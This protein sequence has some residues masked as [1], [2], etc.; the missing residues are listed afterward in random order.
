MLVFE[1][2]NKQRGTSHHPMSDA[3]EAA[4][5]LEDLPVANPAKAVA[6]AAAWLESIEL[7]TGFTVAHRLRI[8][9][10]IDEAA[11][12]SLKQLTL[13]YVGARAGVAAG[14]AD[15]WRAL[16]EYLEKLASAYAQGIEACE[17]RPEPE[18][19][20]RMPLFLTRTMRA[21]ASKIAVGWMRYLPPDRSS[22]ETLVRCYRIAAGHKLVTAPVQAYP[23][24][25]AMTCVASELSAAVMFAAAAPETL[26]PRQIELAYRVAC[27]YAGAF[28]C[29]ATRDEHC[30]MYM[31]LERPGP[32][33]RILNDLEATGAKVFFA[34]GSVLAKLNAVLDET[35]SSVRGPFGDE[36]GRTE[37]LAALQHAAVFWS[38]NAPVRRE[39]RTRIDS[40]IR[41]VVGVR[42][43]QLELGLAEDSREESVDWGLDASGDAAVERTSPPPIQTT[44]TPDTWT[45]TDFSSRGI[46][47]RFFRRPAAQLG[48]G[49]LFGFRL[50]RSSRWC[51]AIVR[52]LRRDGHNH[53]DI[54]AEIIAKGADLVG[55]E[56][57]VGDA[58]RTPAH[59][60]V[61]H[62]R[63][64]L[65]PDAPVLKN[66]PSLLFEPGTNMSGQM[67]FM[68]LDN[69][70]RRIRLGSV[71]ESVDGWD[72]VSF[73]WLDG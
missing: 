5:L 71:M 21:V 47:A 11:N 27:A 66:E 24:E 19:T 42:N 7:E 48:I 58:P 35:G 33:V 15:S 23:A 40:V 1:W 55:L 41:V 18:L 44:A 59:S 32:P 10:M 72:R 70:A 57:A 63:A 60:R 61:M 50:E 37:T 28:A 29:C 9:G 3:R 73:E 56:L 8:V 49:S 39:P 53:T 14:R 54:G 26:S 13:D 12:R 25:V 43:L 36:F 69:G 38:D 68:Y 62:T 45:L 2:G 65:L 34:P 52:R 67:F 17:Q 64:V 31:D 16:T 22:W 30:R 6:E 46:S 20:P 4:R 51:V